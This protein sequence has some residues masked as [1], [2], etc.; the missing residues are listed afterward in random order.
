MNNNE[1]SDLKISGSGRTSGGVF[2]NVTISGSGDVTGNIECSD[3]SISGSGRVSGSIKAKNIHISGSAKMENGV[4]CEDELK[5]SGSA[6]FGGDV[7]CGSLHVSGS[8]HIGGSLTADQVSISGSTKIAGD[9]NA[10]HFCTDGG[11]QIDGL[12]NAGVIELHLHSW[13]SHVKEIGGES[14]T[15]TRSLYGRLSRFFGLYGKFLLETGTIEG[16]DIS[17]EG[18]KAQVVRGTNVKIGEG[19]EIGLVEYTGTFEKT[20]D[21]L[22][23]ENH[24]I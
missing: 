15:V 7:K 17:L 5:V 2:N 10:E 14:I 21:A 8:S 6:K 4:E 12:L 16:D 1:A 18:V 19:C 9:C 13:S 24:K 20:G 3:F 22:I 11:F 23:K